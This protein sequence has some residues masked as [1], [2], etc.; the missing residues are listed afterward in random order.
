MVVV[1]ALDI[2]EVLDFEIIIAC[3]FKHSFI[4]ADPAV[5]L[6]IHI[7]PVVSMAVVSEPHPSFPVQKICD[8]LVV[9]NRTYTPV[10]IAARVV[11]CVASVTDFSVL[12]SLAVLDWCG[13]V[14][15]TKTTL[16]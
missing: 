2:R 5:P 4:Q 10:L 1:W 15:S 6:S 3:V 16:T 14:G 8:V 7:V 11:D 9:W 12:V 13:D